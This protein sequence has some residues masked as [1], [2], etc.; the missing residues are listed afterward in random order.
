MP[1]LVG[2]VFHHMSSVWNLIDFGVAT[3]SLF[4]FILKTSQRWDEDVCWALGTAPR[5]MLALNTILLTWRLLHTLLVSQHL[6][7][8][9]QALILSVRGVMSFLVI[10]LTIT[11]GCAGAFHVLF[12]LVNG[13]DTVRGGRRTPDTDR[14]LG[15]T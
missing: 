6:G 2:V 5:D 8:I 7:P 4:Y 11:F 1:S 13:Y 3:I 14:S 9:I 15:R 10:W 12:P